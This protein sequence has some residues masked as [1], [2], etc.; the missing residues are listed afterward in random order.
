MCCQSA[1][2]IKN[3]QPLN[4]SCDDHNVDVGGKWL[5]TKAVSLILS[6]LIDAQMHPSEARQLFRQLDKPTS[7]MCPGYLQVR[8]LWNA[9]DHAALANSRSA[10]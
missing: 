10:D 1:A 3:P 9:A 4:C 6:H 8:L 2:E 7:G 5:E